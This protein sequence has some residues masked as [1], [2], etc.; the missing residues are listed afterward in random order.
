MN[1]A[2]IGIGIRNLESGIWNQKWIRQLIGDNVV[3]ITRAEVLKI[4]DLARLHFSEEELDA[5]TAQFQRIL[6][7]VEQ[8]EKVD[9]DG[10]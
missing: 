1:R 2:C 8:L 9:V 10:H 3:A 6:D 4:A 7:Y 5:F